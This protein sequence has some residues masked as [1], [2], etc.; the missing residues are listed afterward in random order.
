MQEARGLTKC[1]YIIIK[2]RLLL[3]LCERLLVRGDYCKSAVTLF[4]L[5]P[6][7]DVAF[8]IPSILGSIW[9]CTILALIVSPIAR[10]LFLRFLV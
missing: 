6:R 8:V 4:G 10:F 3:Q 5:A 2:H 9:C 1:T 7:F